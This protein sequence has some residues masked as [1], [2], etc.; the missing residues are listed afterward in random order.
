MIWIKQPFPQ[1]WV[2]P[3]YTGKYTWGI[4]ARTWAYGQ[5][6][7][8]ASFSTKH[9]FCLN[10]FKP[11][12][13]PKSFKIYDT[14]ERFLR[15]SSKEQR[16]WEC[17]W[18]NGKKRNKRNGARN[19]VNSRTVY[20]PKMMENNQLQIST[21]VGSDLGE[22]GISVSLSQCGRYSALFKG[23]NI[24]LPGEKLTQQP[25]NQVFLN[26][27]MEHCS[28]TSRDRTRLFHNSWLT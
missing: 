14:L 24:H 15:L 8:N 6:D 20:L 28:Q 27:T 7:L 3:I 2:K 26:L 25:I 5:W 23:L 13:F 12:F 21:L 17:E 11:F 4:H 9:T 10:K 1:G 16:K 19:K 18:E 22:Y